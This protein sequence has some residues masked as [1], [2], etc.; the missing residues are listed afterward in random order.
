[1]LDPLS[2]FPARSCRAVCVLCASA[3]RRTGY[4]ACINGTYL[5]AV[6]GCG[7]IWCVVWFRVLDGVVLDVL[8]DMCFTLDVVL[9]GIKVGSGYVPKLV[10]YA[11]DVL[12]W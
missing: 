4:W 2:S 9:W 6:G 3:Q 1:M 10:S 12:F 8:L 11:A 7:S 5:F